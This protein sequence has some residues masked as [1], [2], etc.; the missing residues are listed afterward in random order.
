MPATKTEQRFPRKPWKERID[1]RE[2][3]CNHAST[4]QKKSA[5]TDSAARAQWPESRT[6]TVAAIDCLNLPANGPQ[7]RRRHAIQS[8]NSTMQAKLYSKKSLA[9]PKRRPTVLEGRRT[10]TLEN[11]LNAQAMLTHA[12]DDLNDRRVPLSQPLLMLAFTFSGLPARFLAI[13]G[14]GE[15]SAHL[16]YQLP[17]ALV[18]HRHIGKSSVLLDCFSALKALVCK[19][20]LRGWLGWPRVKGSSYSA[21]RN[22]RPVTRRQTF[23]KL[24]KR[25]NS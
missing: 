19:W 14:L 8:L 11:A 22:W 13:I 7:V 10:C 20:H 21:G 2:Q 18:S 15:G 9:I 24:A 25:A 16:I 6:T 5:F 4:T 3:V 23:C 1:T 17:K 12:G